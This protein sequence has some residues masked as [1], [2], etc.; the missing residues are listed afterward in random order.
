MRYP[1]LIAAGVLLLG[2]AFAAK[3]PGDDTSNPAYKDV[4]INVED[5]ASRMRT[6]FF[7]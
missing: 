3:K 1:Y 5:H 2:A 7:A 6:A 4:K